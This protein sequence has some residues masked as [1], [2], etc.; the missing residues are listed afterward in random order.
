MADKSLD[1]PLFSP[2]TGRMV[3]SIAKEVLAGEITAAKKNYDA[4]IAHSS[5]A[6]C[7]WKTLW[8]TPSLLSSTIHRVTRS[9]QCCWKQTDP[10]KPRLF[11]GKI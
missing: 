3:L 9:A 10:P 7:D 1:Q 11:T 6:P 4:A 5:S 8:C 2:N